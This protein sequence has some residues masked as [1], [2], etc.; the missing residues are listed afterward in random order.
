MCHGYAP[1]NTVSDNTFI[2]CIPVGVMVGNYNSYYIAN[3]PIEAGSRSVIS[4]NEFI[5]TTGLDVWVHFLL[6]R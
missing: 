6:I 1:E 2:D 3:W 5:D 4:D